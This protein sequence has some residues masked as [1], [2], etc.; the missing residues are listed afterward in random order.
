MKDFKDYNYE[1]FNVIIDMSQ[2]KNSSDGTS[3]V[4]ICRRIKK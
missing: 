1:D 4:G 2:E 3:R